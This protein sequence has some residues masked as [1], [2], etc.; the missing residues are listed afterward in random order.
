MNEGF[1]IK[2]KRNYR[3]FTVMKILYKNKTI[4]EKQYQIFRF[5]LTCEN[6]FFF[7]LQ[8]QI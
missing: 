6:K 2:I 4:L 1:I 5:I 3:N 7:E 8:P